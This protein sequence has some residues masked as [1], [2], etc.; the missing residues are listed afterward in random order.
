ME[1]RKEVVEREANPAMFVCVCQV[2]GYNPCMT[3]EE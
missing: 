1:I 3:K 2:S